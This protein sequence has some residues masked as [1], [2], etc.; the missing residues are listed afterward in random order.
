MN[1]EKETL[2]PEPKR[3]PEAYRTNL[4]LARQVI[5]QLRDQA[6]EAE[7]PFHVGDLDLDTAAL[8]ALWDGLDR[9]DT[10]FWHEEGME[11]VQRNAHP[12]GGRHAVDGGWGA[13]LGRKLH[14]ARPQDI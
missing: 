9:I 7:E 3:P 5:A 6:M 4:L 13:E 10:H 1:H 2:L 8:D 12:R 14:L 11:R